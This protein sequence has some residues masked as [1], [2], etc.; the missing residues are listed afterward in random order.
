TF[1]DMLDA[2]LVAGQTVRTLG[3]FIPGD[4]GQATYKVIPRSQVMNDN[5]TVDDVSVAWLKNK[6]D[7]AVLIQE[8]EGGAW[9]KNAFGNVLTKA[10]DFLN[11]GHSQH[12][13]NTVSIRGGSTWITETLDL[14]YLNIIADDTGQINVNPVN[15]NGDWAVTI[16]Q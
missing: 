5:H 11:R 7:L 6:S 2:D 4:A 16:R 8:P 14:T 9:H 15:V 12:P 13:T 1:D 3:F 10:A